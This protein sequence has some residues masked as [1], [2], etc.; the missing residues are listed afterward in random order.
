MKGKGRV[1]KTKDTQVLLRCSDN[2]PK[3][4]DVVTLEWGGD[5][6]N[7][8]NNLYWKCLSIISDHT[9]HSKEELHSYYATKYLG[10]KIEIFDEPFVFY[11]STALLKKDEFSQY[12]TDIRFHADDYGITLPIE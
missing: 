6:T 10:D 12:L 8:Q 4:G 1:I 9:G 3:V 2:P 7:P 5:R 11:K